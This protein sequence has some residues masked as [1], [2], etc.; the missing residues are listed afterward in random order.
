VKEKMK[1]IKEQKLKAGIVCTHYMVAVADLGQVV[2]EEGESR[3]VMTSL[4]SN[5]N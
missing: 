4:S 3:S 2:E 5:I 1:K